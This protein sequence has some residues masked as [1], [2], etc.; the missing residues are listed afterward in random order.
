MG[1]I[2]HSRWAMAA[3]SG[4]ILQ[5][6]IRPDISFMEAGKISD[7]GS[8]ASLGSLLVI[9]F[10]LMTFVEGR[11]WQ[12]IRDAG[13]N[14]NPKG[15][16]M[17]FERLFA[18]GADV[19]YPGAIFDPAGMSKCGREEF[20]ILKTKEIKNGRIAMMAYVGISCSYVSSG[21]GPLEALAF[22]LQNPWDHNVLYNT[23]SF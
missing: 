3:V 23:Y 15:N 2:Q 11:R 17:G 5:E 21:K 10:I 22:H 9:Q 19:G 12:D 8:Y 7:S 4:I 6:S 20:E 16:L 13:S 1:E 14:I 18:G